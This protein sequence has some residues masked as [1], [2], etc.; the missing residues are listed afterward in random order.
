MFEA[1]QQL[2][3]QVACTGEL[4]HNTVE[5]E[6]RDTQGNTTFSP[7]G[8]VEGIGGA[9]VRAHYLADSH[10]YAYSITPIEDSVNLGEDGLRSNLHFCVPCLV[11]LVRCSNQWPRIEYL[12]KAV[13]LYFNDDFLAILYRT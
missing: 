9:C 3:E 1:E 10:H 8:G 6:Y 2:G 11:L 5:D 12:F 13:R 7:L 4:D